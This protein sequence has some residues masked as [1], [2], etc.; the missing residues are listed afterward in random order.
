MKKESQI[1]KR[2]FLLIIIIL[3]TIIISRLVVFLGDPNLAIKGLE[4]HHFYL[5][6]LLLSVINILLLFSEVKKVHVILSAI[7]VGLV[8]DEFI[9]VVGKVRGPIDYGLT[10]YPSIILLFITLVII[11]L[12]FLLTK[13]FRK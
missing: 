9:F 12:I 5:G 6:V 13:L 10:I 1:K 3:I 7:G 8:F 4:L 2:I 11:L